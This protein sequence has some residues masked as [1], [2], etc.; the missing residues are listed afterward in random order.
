MQLGNLWELVFPAGNHLIAEKLL[1][2]IPL[3]M[4]LLLQ[5]LGVLRLLVCN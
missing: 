4:T 3:V 1:P 2:L 5:I